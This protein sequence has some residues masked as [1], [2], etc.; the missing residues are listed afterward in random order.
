MS[1]SEIFRPGMR[2]YLIPLVAGLALAGS[3]FLPWVTI[4]DMSLAG[5]PDVMALWVLGLG[6]LAATLATLSLITR[7]NSRHP[8]LIIGLAGLGITFLATRIM[9]SA[10][11]RRATIRAQAIAIVDDVPTEA[12]PDVRI[13][14]GLYLGLAASLVLV[15]F[16]FT[17]VIR[18]AS[19]PYD[20]ADPNDDV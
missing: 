14:A 5:F 19:R 15:G 6:T 2:T 13:D 8:L 10:I 1:W 3:V 9:P 18:R 17:I 16:G 4:G 12:T 11:E 7:R 20:A